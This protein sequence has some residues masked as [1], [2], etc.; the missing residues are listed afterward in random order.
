[1]SISYRYLDLS[2]ALNEVELVQSGAFKIDQLIELEDFHI[3]P[4]TESA[5]S[6]ARLHEIR[7]GIFDLLKINPSNEETPKVLDAKW[8]AHF[9]RT[10]TK[11]LPDILTDMSPADGFQTEVWSYLTL[12]VLPDLA[13]IRW[14]ANDQERFLGNPERNCFQRLWQRAYVLGGEL[15]SQLQEDEAIKMFERTEAIGSNRQLARSM[16]L[17]IVT[18]RNGH[19]K[20]PTGSGMSSL[21]VAQAAKRIRRSMS[22]LSVQSMSEGELDNFVEENFREATFNVENKE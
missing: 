7:T 12:R 22:V 17:Y 19:K 8:R 2:T 10:L 16:A 20:L 6:I 5:I 18:H 21:I 13:L 11:E 1:M 15:A 3:R 9:D 4:F 14:P